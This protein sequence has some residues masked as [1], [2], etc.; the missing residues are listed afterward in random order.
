M[1]DSSQKELKLLLHKYWGYEA[2]RPGQLEIISAILS[3]FDTLAVLP[4]GA[5]KSLCYQ[6]PGL[7]LEGIT[8]VVSPLIALMKDQISSLKIRNI[9]A[10]GLFSGQSY[11]E[12]DIILDNAVYGDQKFL[13]VSPERLKSK[14]FQERLKKMQV[15]LIAIDEAHC[16][17]EWGHDFRP[18]YRKIADIKEVCPDVPFIAVTATATPDVIVDIEANLGMRN[19]KKFVHSPLRS[20]LSY[21][22]LYTEAKK[23]Y[24]YHFLKNTPESKIVYVN[25][26]KQSK[27][28]ERHLL[29]KGLHCRAFHG[30]ME[31]KEREKC[32]EEWNKNTTR[33]I[34]ATKAFGMGIDK[35]DVRLVLHYNPP[36]TIESYVQEAGRAGRDGEVAQS[37]IFY[38]KGDGAMMKKTIEESF[39]EIEYLKE[40]YKNLCQDL[41]VASGPCQTEFYPF[42]VAAFS[43]KFSERKFKVFNAV[44][45][46]HQFEIIFLSEAILHPSRFKFHENR[47]KALLSNPKLT[48]KMGEFIKQVLRNYEGLF[49]EFTVIDEHNI[50][51]KFDTSTKKVKEALNWLHNNRIAEYKPAFMGHTISFKEYRYPSNKLPIDEKVYLERKGAML[52]SIESLQEFMTLDKC[53]QVYIAEFFGFPEADCR[54]C[55]NCIAKYE[56]QNIDL[57][58]NEILDVLNT[59]PKT[60][61]ELFAHFDIGKRE[62][63][64]EGIKMLEDEN[65][66]TI[67]FNKIRRTSEY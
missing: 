48:P 60:I 1:F 41:N 26:R 29:A 8:I 62:E 59:G 57:T 67:E 46:L 7:Y 14:L 22:C 36:Q 18:E 31:R 9:K 3:G 66:I 2:F 13:F 5:G 16:I 20:N 10:S 23:D 17:S 49:L 58:A 56:V 65:E 50:S 34:I 61:I 51:K 55:D 11:R 33:I 54:I 12:Q 63:V 28:L 19:T 30:G 21:N 39:P 53:R 38:N 40:T 35:S 24:L 64:T 27:E 37:I 43:K 44:K 15:A 47:T 52:K 4:T 45:L 42:Y 25:T 32:I 6:I